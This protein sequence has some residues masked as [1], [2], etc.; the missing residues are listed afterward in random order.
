MNPEALEHKTG[1]SGFMQSK[2]TLTMLVYNNIEE[3]H[4]VKLCVIGKYKQPRYFK[5]I[6][7]SPVFRCLENSVIQ[8]PSSRSSAG[9][10]GVH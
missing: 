8:Q 3:T 6:K 9:K 7:C 1:A 10:E 2:D 4:K 5:I